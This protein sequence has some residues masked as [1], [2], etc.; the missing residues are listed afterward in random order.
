MAKL[1]M[2]KPRLEAVRHVATKA[3]AVSVQRVTGRALQ[4]RRLEAWTAS[5]FCAMCDRVVEYPGGF[6][7]DHR[8]ALEH[9]GPDTPDNW[10]VL[11]IR[12]EYIDGQRI[13]TGCHVNKT[14]EERCK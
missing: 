12:V 13:K 10:Q 1:K 3:T 11:C 9:G 7:L 6:E 5:P 14:A 4:R 2:L 8:V